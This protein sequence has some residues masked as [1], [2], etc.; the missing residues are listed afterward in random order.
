MLRYDGAEPC[1]K[2]WIVKGV[3]AGIYF[4]DN[5]Q[6]DKAKEHYKATLRRIRHSPEYKKSKAA[7]D[8]YKAK[9]KRNPVCDCGKLKSPTLLMCKECRI[10]Y[11]REYQR[12][13]KKGRDRRAWAKRDNK[14]C[15]CGAVIAYN[16]RKC[17]KC[18]AIKIKEN[19]A[20][21]RARR[22]NAKRTEEA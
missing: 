14:Y 22:K 11:N 1:N 18:L 3:V 10:I 8:R 6:G 21:N 9:Y 5:S 19:N 4:A 2:E 15:G 12:L 17:D 13:Y 20:R 7:S 16:R